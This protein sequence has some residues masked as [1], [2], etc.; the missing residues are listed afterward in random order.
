[1]LVGAVRADYPPLWFVPAEYLVAFGGPALR[2]DRQWP[3]DPEN[4]GMAHRVRQYFL[5]SDAEA[6]PRPVRMPSRR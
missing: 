6:E 1:M 2:F 3:D 5:V 4:K